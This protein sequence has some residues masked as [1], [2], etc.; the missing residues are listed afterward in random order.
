MP[1]RQDGVTAA[2]TGQT[3]TQVNSK[4]TGL[5]TIS[6]GTMTGGE[7]STRLYELQLTTPEYYY[8]NYQLCETSNSTG[9]ILSPEADGTKIHQSGRGHRM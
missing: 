4:H 7:N 9:M 1:G 2:D 6:T 5:T 3:R 8:Y